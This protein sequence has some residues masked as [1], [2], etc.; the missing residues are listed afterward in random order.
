MQRAHKCCNTYSNMQS[1][2]TVVAQVFAARL[3][4]EIN[5]LFTMHVDFKGEGTPMRVE[6]ANPD[7]Q[8][9]S[10]GSV[11]AYIA[12][13]LRLTAPFVKGRTFRSFTSSQI[14][15]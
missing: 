13:A 11:R 7:Q 5:G 9:I 6:C 1:H 15:V 2:T 10:F 3:P 12:S 4:L 8:A 14:R